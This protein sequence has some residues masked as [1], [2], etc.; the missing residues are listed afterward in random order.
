MNGSLVIEKIAGTESTAN[1][2]SENSMTIK[3]T[4]SPVK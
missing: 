4:N 2:T 3:T 1:I